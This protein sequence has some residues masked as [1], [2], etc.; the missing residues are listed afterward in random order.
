MQHVH[1]GF[2]GADN[3]VG[4][5]YQ[6]HV[7]ERATMA[8]ADTDEASDN[9]TP[10]PG[11]G[12]EPQPRQR[13]RTRDHR[14]AARQARKRSKIK[15]DRDAGAAKDAPP[16]SPVDAPPLARTVTQTARNGVTP[17]RETLSKWRNTP[18]VKR[19]PRYASIPLA[20]IAYGFFALG[21]S[22][23]IWNAWTSGPIANTILPAAMGVLAESVMFFLP[24]RTISLSW[25][26]KG[27]AWAFLLLVAVF[28][29]TNSLRM[30]SIVSAD[31]A[32]VRADR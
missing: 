6:A 3:F 21:I 11:A 25:G 12:A 30:A 22:I 5:E 27:L 13:R 7:P 18:A 15:A 9:V 17:S 29:L 19:Q 16:L 20:V 23:N 8:Q 26:G 10:F 2:G 32:A 4:I 14:A 28:A 1:A 24:E 31:Q